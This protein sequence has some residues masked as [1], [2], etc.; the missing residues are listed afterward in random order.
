MYLLGDIGNL[1]ITERSV[2]TEDIAEKRE[3]NKPS[4]TWSDVVS[5]GRSVG[6]EGTKTGQKPAKPAKGVHFLE[7]R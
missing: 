5:R 4:V 2:I 6:S 7:N 3:G 1:E